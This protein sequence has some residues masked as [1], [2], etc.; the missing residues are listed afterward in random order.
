[1][2][3]LEVDAAPARTTA[4]ARRG[5][6]G[7]PPRTRPSCRRR[8][9]GRRSLCPPVPAGAIHARRWPYRV[10]GAA[11][12]RRK[13]GRLLPHT[14]PGSMPGHTLAEIANAANFRDVE[15][16]GDFLGLRQGQRRS[17][18]R[19]RSALQ[20]AAY[21]GDSDADLCVVGSAKQLHRADAR[22]A[23]LERQPSLDAWPLDE[24]AVI[25]RF[26]AR[27]LLLERPRSPSGD[28]AASAAQDPEVES[29]N[30]RLALF[31]ERYRDAGEAGHL[32]AD[33]RDSDEEEEQGAMQAVS[34]LLAPRSDGRSPALRPPEQST[35]CR[36][37]LAPAAT[38]PS[39]SPTRH[40]PLRI[41]GPR[42]GERGGARARAPRARRSHQSCSLAG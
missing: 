24:D 2:V 17:R 40:S 27:A 10:A 36:G 19:R 8:A 6:R 23:A 28:A 11:G 31:F 12:L 29:R 20:R 3:V 22:A 35:S 30:E 7:L 14:R 18:K 39:R 9:C 38:A 21:P 15:R 34:G 32:A 33:F 41:A 16:P 5:A 42:R 4:S 13:W 25:D 37:A 1:M 26:D